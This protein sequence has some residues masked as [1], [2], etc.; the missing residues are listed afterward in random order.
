MV[1]VATSLAVN[2]SVSALS[3][4]Q[5]LNSVLVFAGSGRRISCEEKLKPFQLLTLKMTDC[6]V[7]PL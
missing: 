3:V 6:L 1:S 4:N 5:P 2:F 7:A